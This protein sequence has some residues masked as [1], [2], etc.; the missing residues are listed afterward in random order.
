MHVGLFVEFPVSIHLGA[1]PTPL[2]QSQ[3]PRPNCFLPLAVRNIC[4]RT[5]ATDVVTPL[6]N[7]D[8]Q[9]SSADVPWLAHATGPVATASN[10]GHDSVS[11]TDDR[12]G[13]RMSPRARV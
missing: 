12:V 2:D 6:S 11:R 4:L 5:Y 8:T 10:A 1:V 9:T 7:T 3:R 13:K